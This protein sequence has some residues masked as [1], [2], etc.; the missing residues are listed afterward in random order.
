MITAAYVDPSVMSYTVQALAG[1][2]IALGVVFGVVWRKI[3]K[4][5]KNVLQIDENSGKEI[6]AEVTITDDDE[7]K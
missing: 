1:A 7:A 2:V 6:E 4:G 5:A 3:K